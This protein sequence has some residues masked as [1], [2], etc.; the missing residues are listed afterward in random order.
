M[1]IYIISC[2]PSKHLLKT[3]SIEKKL[4]IISRLEK[5]EQI[6]QVCCNV[7]FAHSSIHTVH[8]NADRITDSVKS[9]TEVFV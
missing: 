5:G 7:G 2:N 8:D 1:Y 3:I 4:D 9:G 6:V